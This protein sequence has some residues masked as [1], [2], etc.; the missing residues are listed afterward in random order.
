MPS[1]TLAKLSWST[2]DGRP[3]FSNLNLS[4]GAER[5][6]VVGR[7]GVGK[8]TLLKLIIGELVASSGTICVSGSHALLRQ[9]VQVRPEETIADLFGVRHALAVLARAD[10]GVAAASELANADWMLDARMHQALTRAGLEADAETSLATLSGGQ[11]TR[12]GLAAMLFAE[13]DFLILD[14][15]TNNLDRDGRRAVID[16]LAGWRGGAIIVS[17]DRE[18]LETVDAIIEMTSLGA[19]RYGGNWS[20]YRERKSR[21]LAAIE[22]DLAS[23]EK[24]VAEVNQSTQVTAERKARRDAGG[25]RRSAK[26]DMPRI[27]AGG[28][29]RRAENTFGA[30]ARLAARLRSQAA[31]D[32]LA[33][34]EKIEILQPLSVTL[35]STGLP[36][37]KVV[38]RIDGGTAGYHAEKPVLRDLSF[39]I[40]GPERIAVIGPNGSGKTTLLSLISGGL[41]LFSGTMRVAVKVAMLDQRVSMLNPALSIRDN[42]RLLD[43]EADEND[44]RAALARFM[45][46]A[47]AALQ[48]VGTLSGGQMLRAGL[49]CVLGCPQPPSLL[50]LDE[51]TNNLDIDSIAAV[52]AGLSAYDGALL[53]ASHDEMFLR[54]IGVTRRLELDPTR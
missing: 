52:E 31:D 41:R 7:N 15:P 46:R 48:R 3:L 47:D 25:K 40:T 16:L 2:P 20:R 18:L 22:H 50:V 26:G 13:P 49:A 43:P 19:T 45:F 33:A 12:A 5:A 4:F 29:K 23:A 10:A 51:P 35:P 39:E 32:L 9:T 44:C 21:E 38:L 28:M 34:R 1:I 24:Q 42:F 8:T 54:A 37:T 17:H 27:V 36:S 30:N 14:E 53:V 11:R 6:G